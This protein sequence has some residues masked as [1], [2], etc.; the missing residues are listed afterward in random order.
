MRSR[1]DIVESFSSFIQLGSDA[2]QGWLTDPKLRRS[3]EVNLRKLSDSTTSETFWVIFWHKKWQEKSYPLSQDHLC[4]YLQESCY[5][6]AQSTVGRFCNLQY[7]L[8]DGF[9]I[10]IA[11]VDKVLT[12]FDQ[13][14]G[15]SL[16][17]YGSQIFRSVITNTLR[18][19]KETDICSDWAL[20]RKISKKRLAIALKTVGLTHQEIEKYQLAWYCFLEIYTPNQA[21][22][23]RQ[24]TAPTT[25]IFLEIIKVYHQKSNSI[26]DANQT[27]LTPERLEKWLRKCAKAVRSYLYPQTTSLNIKKGNDDSRELIENLEASD[28]S[29]IDELMIKEEIEKRQKQTLGI[30]DFLNK[31]INELSPEIKNILN[32]YYRENLTQKD[33]AKQ[34]KMKQYTVSRRL[35]KGKQLLLKGVTQWSQKEFNVSLNT[36]RVEQMSGI[37]EEWLG[38]YYAEHH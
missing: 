15:N 35:T 30:D 20:L 19:R 2:F 29:L 9:Q 12:G 6:A 18:Q 36:E 1:Q 21:Q 16:K 22:G 8:S 7:K 17:S 28:E 3:M 24:L 37:L 25:E 26:T 4:A 13:E 38:S 14:V 23:T 5:W 31:S 34:L 27:A 32:F 11:S 33:I 10:A